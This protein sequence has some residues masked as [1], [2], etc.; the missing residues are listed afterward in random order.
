VKIACVGGGPAGLYLSVLLKLRDPGHE[1]TVYERSKANSTS[2]WGVTFGR[3]L[4]DRLRAADP[5]SAEQVV[6]SAFC[7]HDQITHIRGEQAVDHG[8]EAYNISRRRLIDILTSR[9]LALGVRIEYGT[10]ITDL[11]QLPDADL[12]VAAD[13][14][15]SDVRDAAEGFTP[16][17]VA[18]RNKYIWLGSNKVFDAFNFFFTQTEHGWIWAHAYGIDTESS[19]FIVECSAQAW[20]GFG[21]ETMSTREALPVLE[22]LF[23]EHLDGQRLIG[24]LGDGST[25]RWLNFKTVSNE[26]WHSGRVV[27][28]GDSARTAHFSVGMGTRLALEDV[29]LL[30]DLLHREAELGTALESYQRQRKNEVAATLAEAHC[31]ARWLENVDRYARLRPQQFGV[32]LYA[33][34]SPLVAVLPPRLA[35]RL[36]QGAQ[37]IQAVDTLRDSIAPAVKAVYGRRKAPAGR[38]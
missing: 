10:E 20:A 22:G 32:L 26:H 33:R 37:Q 27:L 16:E 2:G 18:G 36:R 25:A 24:E 31:S 35:Y 11:G 29:M 23:R 9:A 17:T 34:R 28:V 30:A 1:V 38:G 3:D 8:G 5:V 6:A 14:V 19:T 7:W 21:F 12:I 4:R 13:G 15:N